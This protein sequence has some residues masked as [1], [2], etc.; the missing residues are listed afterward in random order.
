MRGKCTTDHISPAGPWLMYRGHL[1]KMSD[2]LLLGAVN[3]YTGVAGSGKNIL[4][5]KIE[6]FPYIAESIKKK[7]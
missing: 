7:T 4:N 2:N 5:G 3:A 6:S 1:D